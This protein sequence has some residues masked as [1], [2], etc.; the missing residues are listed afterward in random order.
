MF[1][2]NNKQIINKR[3]WV[4]IRIKPPDLCLSFQKFKY[5]AHFVSWNLVSCPPILLLGSF[6][7]WIHESIYLYIVYANL[8]RLSIRD[9]VRNFVPE[10]KAT[11]SWLKGR[12][13]HTCIYIKKMFHCVWGLSFEVFFFFL[14][15][16]LIDSNVRLSQVKRPLPEAIY[17]LKALEKEC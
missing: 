3:Q 10:A 17:I 14:L 1:E 2:K 5:F 9:V 13:N 12:I 8:W 4:I 6:K 11:I 15:S 16:I 7:K